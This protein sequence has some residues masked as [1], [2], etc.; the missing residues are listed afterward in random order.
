MLSQQKENCKRN[1]ETARTF[2]RNLNECP[3]VLKC[4]RRLEEAAGSFLAGIPDKLATQTFCALILLGKL[5]KLSQQFI[6][7]VVILIC[8]LICDS[9][10]MWDSQNV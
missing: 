4:N 3:A 6:V 1:M 7:A 9:L 5:A 10:R 2:S 8:L